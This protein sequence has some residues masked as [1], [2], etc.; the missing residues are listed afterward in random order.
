MPRWH[1]PPDEG[2]RHTIEEAL[3][4]LDLEHDPSMEE[5]VGMS[6]EEITQHAMQALTV[7]IGANDLK[8]DDPSTLVQIYILGFVIGSKYGEKRAQQ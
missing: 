1:A 7:L 4:D 6:M 2:L 8:L 3:T 5:V